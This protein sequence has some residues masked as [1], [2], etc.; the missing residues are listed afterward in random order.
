MNSGNWVIYISL[1]FVFINK[2]LQYTSTYHERWATKFALPNVRIAGD[3]YRQKLSEHKKLAGINRSISAQDDYARWTKNNRKLTQL[4]NEL[5]K[6][7]EDLANASAKNKQILGRLRLLSLTI[8]FI[9]LKLWKGK[10][11]VYYLPK[12]NVFPRIISGVWS[13][14]WFYLG[15]AP[16]RMFKSQPIGTASVSEVGVSL[17]I[18]LWALQRVFDT[19]ELLVKQLLLTSVVPEPR[20]S[21]GKDGRY[22]EI[23]S[24]K[25]E[26]D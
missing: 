1:L 24:D 6:L 23:T 2:L 13:E 11:I 10:H 19:I 18:W 21:S 15:M 9:L 14:G 17:G 5:K 22:H 20:L 16:L 3:R 8:P 26:L 4:E 12:S 7:K 25:V